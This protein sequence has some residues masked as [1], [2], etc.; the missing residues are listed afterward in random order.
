MPYPLFLNEMSLIYIRLTQQQRK[1][2]NFKTQKTSQLE[3]EQKE[4]T[5]NFLELVWIM[6][7]FS[8][9]NMMPH[10]KLKRSG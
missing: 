4:A 5:A 1:M 8:S 7:S 6:H 9:F 2:G 10:L 3:L